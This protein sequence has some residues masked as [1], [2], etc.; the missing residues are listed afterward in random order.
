MALPADR[1][2]GLQLLVRCLL[3]ATWCRKASTLLK[4]PPRTFSVLPKTR[5]IMG[6]AAPAAHQVANV[7]ATHIS[8]VCVMGSRACTLSADVMYVK[9]SGK[10]SH[11]LLVRPTSPGLSAAHQSCL[12]VCMSR[13]PLSL[14]AAVRQGYTGCDNGVPHICMQKSSTLQSMPIY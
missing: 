13:P 10:G 14:P 8:S 1:S 7:L 6:K 5:V 4:L 3:W 11:R 2:A 9:I 12:H